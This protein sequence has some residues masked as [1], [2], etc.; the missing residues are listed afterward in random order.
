MG[1]SHLE[2][3]IIGL[4][5]GGGA[6][7]I[8]G[9]LAWLDELRVVAIAMM[10]LDHALFFFVPGETWAAAIRMTLTRCAQ[11]LFIFVLA[12]LTIY[13]NHPMRPRRWL[14]PCWPTW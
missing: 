12:Y 13:L 14:R 1:I 3:R 5:Y 10:V 9:R 11:P 8:Y 6:Y 7:P 2:D 4:P